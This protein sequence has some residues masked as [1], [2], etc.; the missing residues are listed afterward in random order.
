MF[1]IFL[2]RR[3]TNLLY[4]KIKYHS[5]P[6]CLF[7]STFFLFKRR[8]CMQRSFIDYNMPKEKENKSTLCQTF[9]LTKKT[10]MMIVRYGTYNFILVGFF[11][12]MSLRRSF[13][14]TVS[15]K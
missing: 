15:L 2:L 9:L 1:I 10:T 14:L 13:L 7:T 8:I 3:R 6:F 11:F 12:T 4:R 5:F